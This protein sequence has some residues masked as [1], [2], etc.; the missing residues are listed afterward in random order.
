[1]YNNIN[2]ILN[3]TTVQR[4]L[5]R[6]DQLDDGQPTIVAKLYFVNQFPDQCF[7]KLL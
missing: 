2:M 6:F 3:F 4:K 7:L 1:M 5:N